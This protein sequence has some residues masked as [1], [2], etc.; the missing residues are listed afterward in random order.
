MMTENIISL[1]SIRIKAQVCFELDK[2]KIS[3]RPCDTDLYPAV[4]IECFKD[5]RGY[6]LGDTLEVD[7]VAMQSSNG[8]SY[9]YSY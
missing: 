1:E 6:E 8:R 3:L 9:F 5:L 2:G 4:N 7:V